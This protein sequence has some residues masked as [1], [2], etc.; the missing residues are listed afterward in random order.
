MK[1]NKLLYWFL[2]I[3]GA[4]LL[5]ALGSGV[6]SGILSP[7]W[8]GF[9]DIVIRSLSS[10]S[11]VFKNTIYVEAAKGFHEYPPISILFLIYGMVI[12]L[13]IVFIIRGYRRYKDPT[14]KEQ[15]ISPVEVKSKY[16]S[17]CF[18]ILVLLCLILWSIVKI[19]YVN[20]ITTRSLNSVDIIAPF[21]EQKE[22][23]SLKSDF[24]RMKNAEDYEAFHRKMVELSDKHEVELPLFEPL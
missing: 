8:S 21:I 19:Q 12:A 5:S 15:P 13:A 7:T 4:I 23:L 17:T 9:V 3:L 24:L 6:W 2:G 16:I 11:G 22:Y 14:L 18:M 10:I 1:A 20:S